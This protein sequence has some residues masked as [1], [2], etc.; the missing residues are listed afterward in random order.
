MT[1]FL[2]Q[3]AIKHGITLAAVEE[4]KT[5]MGVGFTAPVVAPPGTKGSE[6]YQT[7]LLRLQAPFHNIWLTRNNVGVLMDKGGRPVRYGLANESPAQ[8]AAF[9]SADLIGIHT[10]TVEQQHVGMQ[11]GQFCSVEMKEKGWQYTGD[12]HEQGQLAFAEF[13][14]AKG[15]CAIFAS[16]PHHLFNITGV[17]T[18]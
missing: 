17:K 1:P 6:A 3:W 2:H 10:F 8:N 18:K 7:S 13:V 5:L 12:E 14:I 15:G 4:L 9:K 16:E 11:V